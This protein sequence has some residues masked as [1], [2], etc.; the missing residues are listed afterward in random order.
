MGQTQPY[1]KTLSGSIGAGMGSLFG[2]S[3]KQYY[4]LEHKMNSKYHKAGES[5]EIIID[6]IELGRDTRC[7][8]RFD[9]SFQTVSRRHAAIIKDG[10]KWKLVNL[11]QTNPTFL[12]GRPVQREWFL[13]SGDDIQ[14]SAG[15]PRLGFIIPTGNK[16]TVGSIG[17]SRRMSLFR[18]QALKPYKTAITL[19]TVLLVL[20]IGGLSTWNILQ[21]KANDKKIAVIEREAA[22]QDSIRAAQIDTLVANNKGLEKELKNIRKQLGKKG[23]TGGT[24]KTADCQGCPAEF[25]DYMA[26]VYYIKAEKVVV[27][28]GGETQEFPGWWSGT[29]FLL[30]DGR[31]VTARHVAEPWFFPSDEDELYLNIYASNGGKV[32]THFVANSP[33]GS[34]AAIRF[35]SEQTICNRGADVTKE[36]EDGYTV[37][38]ANGISRD[39]AYIRSGKGS[40][41]TFDGEK[42]T[43]LNIGER[44]TVFGYPL[45]LGSEA[46]SVQP[47][48][49]ETTVSKQGVYNGIILTSDRNFEHGNSG[50]PVFYKNSA[51]KLV[52]IGIVS[53]GVGDTMGAIV[54]ISAIK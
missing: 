50:G 22:R 11:S 18:Q 17:L 8:V 27:T 9:D 38:L 24:A 23:G 15:G 52:V 13:Q 54:P 19:L 44:L 29:G 4:I 14:L 39:W 33:G 35:T 42:S 31:F 41:L 16:S 12:N 43:D 1:K 53:A 28:F 49:S 25:K 10:D 30:S 21:G 51:G 32:V 3:G 48:F 20:A 40:G 7:Q 46:G 5:Q 36:T 26:Y 34:S 37:K 2:G 6:Q 47:I 45:G